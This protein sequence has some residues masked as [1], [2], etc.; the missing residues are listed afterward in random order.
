MNWGN[1]TNPAN[2]FISVSDDTLNGTRCE[3][4]Q[5]A[6][7][8]YGLEGSSKRPSKVQLAKQQNYKNYEYELKK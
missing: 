7:Y 6:P 3:N 5:S 2:Y 1:P 8:W 4:W